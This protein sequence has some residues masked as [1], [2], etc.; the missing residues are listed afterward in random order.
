MPI[1]RPS[2]DPLWGSEI[3]AFLGFFISR[4]FFWVQ[5]GPSPIAKLP[6][7]SGNGFEESWDQNVPFGYKKGAQLNLPT[8]GTGIPDNDK[9]QLH[10]RV[11]SLLP[12]I[13]LSKNYQFSSRDSKR[14]LLIFSIRRN[15]NICYW[16]KYSKIIYTVRYIIP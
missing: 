12:I 4:P 15:A 9:R 16:S 6:K 3:W 7:K 2:G 10:A 5:R 13:S 14:M 8:W 1:L 11:V